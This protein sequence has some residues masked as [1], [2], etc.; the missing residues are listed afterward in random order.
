MYEHEIAE[1]DPVGYQAFKNAQQKEV[2]K[3]MEVQENLTKKKQIKN[4]EISAQGKGD[5]IS[6]NVSARDVDD[7]SF[8]KDS[9]N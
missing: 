5:H 7:E 2:L 1:L 6:G 3:S 8:G 9:V 4:D